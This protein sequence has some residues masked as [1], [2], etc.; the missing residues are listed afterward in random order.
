MAE[1]EKNT[2]DT[3]VLEAPLDKVET[4]DPVESGENT[5]EVDPQTILDVN[6]AADRLTEIENQSLDNNEVARQIEELTCS[7]RFG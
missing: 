7:F 4:V 6:A 2:D 5:S 3:A 1:V